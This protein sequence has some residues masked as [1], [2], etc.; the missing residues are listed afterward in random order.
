M[1]EIESVAED[2]TSTVSLETEAEEEPQAST[3]QPDA[4][5]VSRRPC[6]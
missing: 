4:P 2:L 1:A 3:T 6:W 5:P